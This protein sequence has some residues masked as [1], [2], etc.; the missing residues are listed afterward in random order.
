MHI[1]I[2][3][4]ERLFRAEVRDWLERNIPR[5]ARRSY[6]REHDLAWQ[7]T[8][9]EGGW[10]GITWPK[11]Y[12][13]RG[14][15]LDQMLIW[16]EESARVH[17]PPVGCLFVALNHAG[18]TLIAR[19]T[20]EQQNFH[21]PRI[22]RGEVVWCQGFSEPGAGSD[23]ASL[24]T[25]AVVDGDE[26]VVNGSKI[27]TSSGH[28]ADFQELLVRTDPVAPKHKGITWVICDMRTP[29][30]EVRPIRV[31]TGPTDAH[32]CQVFYSDVRIPL[33]NVVG[34]MND[35]WSVANAT[36]GFERGTGFMAEQIHQAEVLEDLIRLAL[37]RGKDRSRS[38]LDEGDVLYRLATL[39]AEFAAVRAMTYA[40][41]SKIRQGSPGSEASLI[42]LY[43]SEALQRLTRLAMDVLGRR[44]LELSNDKGWTYAYLR[45]F[46]A[47]IAA[48]TS[49]IQRNIIGERVL[50]LPRG[51]RAQ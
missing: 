8:L 30:I 26:L 32:F 46:P 37:E 22:L 48:G 41:L 28:L 42:R 45:S 50:G 47:T 12:G 1:G 13:G 7:R 18:P 36:L 6:V 35:G 29:G 31:M 19:G 5:P 33:S 23:L 34:A 25:R 16:Y 15:S 10:A 40:S 2:T 43:F 27:W 4:D 51:P 44:M 20:P 3:E 49:D 24:K 9:Y 14:L 21:L 11:E 38:A 39:R 17:A